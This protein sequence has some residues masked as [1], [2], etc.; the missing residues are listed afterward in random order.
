M[1]RERLSYIH[2]LMLDYG[3]W[4]RDGRT[5]QGVF[6]TSSWPEGKPQEGAGVSTGRKKNKGLV[7]QSTPKETRSI[8]PKIPCTRVDMRSESIHDIVLSMPD[9]VKKVIV[10]LYLRGLEWRNTCSRLDLTSRK[11]GELK[12]KALK[13]VDSM[14]R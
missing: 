11:L 13:K 1:K 4:L 5:C 9:D 7:S 3:L 14:L 10:C 8:V 12:Y 2:C 6:G